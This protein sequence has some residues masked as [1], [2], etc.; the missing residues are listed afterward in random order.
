MKVNIKQYTGAAKA[1]QID[2]IEHAV[3]VLPDSVRDGKWP[4]FAHA[5]TFRRHVA[6]WGKQPACGAPMSFDLPNPRATRIVLGCIKRGAQPFELLTLARK[7][8]KTLL[9]HHPTRVA[10]SMPGLGTGQAAA[11][12][13]ALLAALLAATHEM[14][15]YKSDVQKK[16]ALR[17][18]HIYNLSRTRD[19]SRTLAIAEGNNLARYL[20]ALP[21]NELTPA[22]YRQRLR[23]L[24]RR[25]GWRMQFLDLKSLARKQAGAFLAVAQGSDTADAGIVHLRYTPK[26]RTAARTLALVGKGICFDSGGLNLKPARYM[27][28]MHEDMAGSAVALGTLLALTHLRA[29][30]QIDCWLA[31]AQNNIGP[32]AYKQNDVITACNGTTIEIM[33]T[34]AEGRMVLADTLALAA[35]ARPA[36]IIDYATLTGS[37]IGALGSYYSGAFTNR[38]K[39]LTDIINAGKTSGERVWPFPND[40]DYDAEL[41]SDI[42]DI[43]QCTL[44]SEADHILASRFLQRFVGETPWLHL[45]LAA[46]NHKGGLAHVPTDT[47]GFGVG[48]TLSLLLDRKLLDK[49]E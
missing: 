35:R 21:P 6:R 22:S 46:I 43:K 29:D 12:A 10:L 27:H 37:C 24:A 48:F 2:A 34:D 47:T 1:A 19:F 39:W 30:F 14:P 8:V 9:A 32:R 45:D 23:Q 44:G 36:L 16:P 18:V 7:L 3:F 5:G 26:R 4:R 28:G 41:D 13:E 33:H 49:N 31:L 20:S 42:A 25:H 17:S 11:M 38:E 40:S 15:S